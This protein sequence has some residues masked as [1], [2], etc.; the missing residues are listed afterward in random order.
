MQLQR[1]ITWSRGR[2]HF[3]KRAK[4]K[5]GDHVG[6]NGIPKGGGR[7]TNV[8]GPDESKMREPAIVLPCWIWLF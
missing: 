1:S 6:P 5:P 4:A 2:R 7:K 8:G 3:L